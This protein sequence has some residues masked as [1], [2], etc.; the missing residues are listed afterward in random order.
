M[1]QSVL[2]FFNIGTP[3]LFVIILVII[4]FFGSKKIP[5]LARGL[6]KGIR[7]VKNATS[8]IQEEIRKTSTAVKD[9]IN[10]TKDINSKPRSSNKDS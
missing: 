10:I 2:L 4:M 1:L 3:E 6:G 5:E 8:D 7:E 9:E